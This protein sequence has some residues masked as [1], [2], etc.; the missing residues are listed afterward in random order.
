MEVGFLKRE[1]L[2]IFRSKFF[3][4]II[5]AFTV[6]ITLP[7]R[8]CHMFEHKF[9]FFFLYNS[10]EKFILSNR[11]QQSVCCIVIKQK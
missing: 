3:K 6:E 4:V 7:L 10:I 9:I 5:F 11:S 2:I 1:V 8:L